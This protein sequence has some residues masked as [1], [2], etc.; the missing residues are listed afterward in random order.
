MQTKDSDRAYL[1]SSGHASRG[2]T[3]LSDPVN[4]VLEEGGRSLKIDIEVSHAITTDLAAYVHHM[5]NI[6]YKL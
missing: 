5:T 4:L 2:P 6:V 1:I 3:L